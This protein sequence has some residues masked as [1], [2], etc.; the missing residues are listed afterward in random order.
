M[1]NSLLSL[2]L[3]KA[4]HGDLQAAAEICQKI[5]CMQLQDAFDFLR[6]GTLASF[7]GQHHKA[8]DL[9]QA[10]ADMAPD[11]HEVWCGLG[12]VY[13]NSGHP[14]QRKVLRRARRTTGSEKGLLMSGEVLYP[15]HIT[16][17]C[18]A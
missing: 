4:T 2:G 12:S 16:R 3:T 7:T 9:I 5:S 1:L 17:V 13:C 15:I 14:E 18:Q 10:A 8:V 6:A 11:N